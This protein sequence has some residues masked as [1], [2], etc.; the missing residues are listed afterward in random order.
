M[1][2]PDMTE[3]QSTLFDA[4]KRSADFRERIDQAREDYKTQLRL[5]KQAEKE[6]QRRRKERRL[7]KK[8]KE[9]KKKLAEESRYGEDVQAD[10]LN[11]TSLDK[12]I[13]A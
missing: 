8:S 6:K 2:T 3:P 1:L 9:K 11:D 5:E 10:M 13:T 12:K 7:R 4:R